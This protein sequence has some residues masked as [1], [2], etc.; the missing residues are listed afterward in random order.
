MSTPTISRPQFS[1]HEPV[2]N[3]N[4]TGTLHFLRLYLR[5]DRIALPLWILI[6]ASAPGLYV[7]SIS[8]IY[9][10]PEQLAAFAATTAASPAEIAMYGPIF[11]SSLGSVGVWKA[12]IYST[13]IAIAVILTIIRHTRAEEENGRT[14]LLDSTSVGRYSSLTAALIVAGGAS[15]LTGILCTASLLT[16][17]LPTAGSVAF[18][19]ALA[20]SGMVFT[21]VAAVAAQL[22][23]SARVARGIAMSALGVAFAL[24]AIGDAG[25]GTLSWFSPLG[26]ALQIRAYADERWWVLLPT[27]VTAAALTWS[28]YALLRRRDVGGGLIAEREGPAVASSSLTG[29][30]GLAWRMQRGTLAAWTVGL[31]LYGLLIGSAAQG[32]GGQVGDSQAIRDI[33]TRMGGSPSLEKSFIGY[34]FIMLGIAAA[35]YTV[36]ASLRLHSEETAQRVEPVTAGSIGRIRWASSH[37]VFAL[38][39]PAIA[40][41][42][43]GVAAGVTYGVANGDVGGTL[44]SILGAALVQLP[45][46]WVLTGVTVF[47]FGVI[48][49]FTPVAWGVFVA[50][51]FIFLV[52]SIAQLPQLVLD[53]EPFTHAPKLPGA[54]FEATPLVWLTLIAAALIATGLAAFRRRDLR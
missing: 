31:G 10:S 43:A 17:N 53:L 37:I 22:T 54:P 46:V 36:S 30:L 24:R 44:P 9:T 15:I 25:S 23:P 12:G 50:F 49:R 51:L 35:A 14:E 1:E 34:A 3:S 52:G 41:L 2:S 8:G 40:L 48:P 38:L 16:H 26:W 45:A 19:A 11:N 6:F 20:G 33:I 5:R 27:L 29:T 42:V 7:A 39:G 13:L 47:L 21:G 28:A 4:F 18:G 32:V